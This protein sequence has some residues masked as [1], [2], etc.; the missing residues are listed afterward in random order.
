MTAVVLARARAVGRATIASRRGRPAE[1]A[2]DVAETLLRIAVL[3][4]AGVTPARAWQHL[5]ELG[6]VAAASVD[7][8]I[9]SGRT[10][11]EALADEARWRDVHAAW[12]I[13]ATV[14]APLAPTLRSFAATLQDARDAADDIRIALA[15]PTATARLIGWLPLVG[16]GLAFAL[17]FDPIGA[18]L[19]NPIGGI[20]GVLGIALLLAGRRWTARLAAAAARDSALPGLDADLVAIALSGG[21]SIERA[22][23]L[24]LTVTG[25]VAGSQEPHPLTG[26]GPGG[27]ESATVAQTLRLS[28][29]AGVPAVELLRA[30]AALERHRAR[31]D[32]RLRAAALSTRLLLPLGVCT[33]PSFL[34]LGV[35]PMFLGVLPAVSVPLPALP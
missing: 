16:M 21:V 17:G 31:V 12:A 14:G 8:A 9:R 32:A 34:C 24:V 22:R 3:V 25:S 7:A 27:A 23:Y 5:A 19:R 26:G 1:P 15:E 2:T 6:D 29:T 13:A 30:G 18:L 4:E 10:V 11:V 33:L 35:V 28:Q 20:C